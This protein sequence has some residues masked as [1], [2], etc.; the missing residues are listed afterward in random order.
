MSGYALSWLETVAV[1]N[2]NLLAGTDAAH[3]LGVV[4][5]LE[6]QRNGTPRNGHITLDNHH[7]SLIAIAVDRLNRDGSDASALT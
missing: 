6:A 3:N 1:A 7:A 5:S 4:G 2:D